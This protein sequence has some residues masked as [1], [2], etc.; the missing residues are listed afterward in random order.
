MALMVPDLVEAEGGNGRIEFAGAVVEPT[1]PI[2][3]QSIAV[4]PL[5]SGA[6][7]Q[8]GHCLMGPASADQQEVFYA[9]S[10]RTLHADESD[11]L[12]R[13]LVERTTAAGTAAMGRLQ[14][15]TYL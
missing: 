10:T 9:S 1:C 4:P 15:V 12:L 8:I 7:T 13:Y 11:Q 3:S 2:A 5:P 14:T 6:P